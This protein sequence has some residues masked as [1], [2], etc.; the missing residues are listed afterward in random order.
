MGTSP[1]DQMIFFHVCGDD[2]WFNYSV[3][4]NVI[5]FNFLP[6]A[7]AERGALLILIDIKVKLRILFSRDIVSDLNWMPLGAA[8]TALV[9]FSQGKFPL[10]EIGITSIIFWLLDQVITV[11]PSEGPIPF[12]CSN[13]L[14]LCSCL[15]EMESC[16][17]KLA[18][19][20][21]FCQCFVER[22]SNYSVVV[23]EKSAKLAVLQA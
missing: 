20:T 17:C 13:L 22:C 19:L 8:I 6:N 10:K 2:K 21:R 18:D 14:Y 9:F 11:F 7:S 5:L 16:D 23:E 4:E 3:V 12:S 15:C 1:L